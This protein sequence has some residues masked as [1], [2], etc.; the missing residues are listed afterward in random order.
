MILV[1]MT[2]ERFIQIC[3]PHQ[4]RINLEK[5]NL[6]RILLALILFCACLN[7]HFWWTYSLYTEDVRNYENPTGLIRNST[8][9]FGV[10]FNSSNFGLDNENVDKVFVDFYTKCS[11]E[12]SDFKKRVYGNWQWI[13]LL[14]YALIPFV[15]ITTM[16]LILLARLLYSVHQRKKN[17]G[18]NVN[19][20]SIGGSSLLL[21]S[22]GLLYLFC[23]GPIGIYH[24]YMHIWTV[25]RT[26]SDNPEKAAFTSF[27]RSILENMSYLTNALSFVVYCISGSRFR[28]EFIS[29]VRCNSTVSEQQTLSSTKSM[30]SLNTTTM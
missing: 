6:V 28:K 10:L 25:N 15:S 14:F 30:S 29:M 9:S 4:T 20:F 8:V 24:I 18:Q 7:G 22:A 5:K 16:N 1:T 19:S 13:N 3:F 11:Y 21:I 2:T 12:D 27:W 26:F 23:T 17:L